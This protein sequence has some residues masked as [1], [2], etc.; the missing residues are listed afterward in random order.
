[1][2]SEWNPRRRSPMDTGNGG[3]GK[4]EKKMNAFAL[5][6][7]VVSFGLVFAAPIW[8]ALHW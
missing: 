4:G 6:L 5:L 3:S 2:G 1:M 8:I 7:L